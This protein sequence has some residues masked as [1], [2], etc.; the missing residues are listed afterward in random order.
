MPII[1][2]WIVYLG[3]SPKYG[4]YYGP[5]R[6]STKLRRILREVGLP[7]MRF[8][9][10]RHSAATITVMLATGVHPKIVQEILGHSDISIMLN[11]YSHMLPSLQREAMKTLE[12]ALVLSV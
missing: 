4:S 7:S 2:L 9:D 1:Y 12:A 8:H 11:T 6:L 3:G 10:L 5:L